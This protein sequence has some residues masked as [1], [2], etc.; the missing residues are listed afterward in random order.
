MKKRSMH[1]IHIDDD[2]WKWYFRKRSN[3]I[4]FAPTGKRYE[5]PLKDY[6]KS[7]D[8]SAEKYVGQYLYEA[9]IQAMIDDMAYTITPGDLKE[10]IIKNLKNQGAS[11]A[12]CQA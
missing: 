8:E 9:G 11:W 3:I 6:I 1:R 2:I 4:I 10:Y 12:L 7:T 5:V